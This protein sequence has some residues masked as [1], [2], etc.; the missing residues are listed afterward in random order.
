M[1]VPVRLA[2]FPRPTITVLLAALWLISASAALSAELIQVTDNPARDWDP[3][4]SPDGSQLVFTSDRDGVG[5][6]YQ[7]PVSTNGERE[8]QVEQ[9]TFGLISDMHPCWSPDGS[10]IAFCSQR[11]G[12]QDIWVVDANGGL[13]EQRTN[14]AY[15]E[16]SLGWSHSGAR[17]TF[18]SNRSGNW[19]IHTINSAGGDAQRLTFH[20]ALDIGP[21]GS[22]DGELIAFTSERSGSGNIWLVPAAGGSPWQLTFENE[23]MTGYPCWSPDDR[24]IA[25]IFYRNGNFDIYTIPAEGGEITPLLT[26]DSNEMY[27]SYSPDGTML[28]FSSNMTGNDEVYILRLDPSS[29]DQGALPDYQRQLH[30]VQP[31]PLRAN[32]TI[33]FVSNCDQ[34]IRIGVY[35]ANGRVIKRLADRV[36]RY[37]MNQIQWNGRT[38]N[39]QPAT[40]GTY[41]LRLESV[42]GIDT[43]KIQ[44]I[45]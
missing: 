33:R 26:Y 41:I 39:D 35:D 29:T 25:F 16:E 3:D 20:A 11:D 30:S 23:G 43:G 37:G 21:N 5:H 12:N 17:I 45:Q 4:W 10:T 15:R 2:T 13:P 28:A 9:L 40:T 14:T 6:L 19:E 7:V 36:F 32:T 18:D 38:E 24:T 22:H 34:N 42:A 31:N 44:L 1:S 27:P 8:A